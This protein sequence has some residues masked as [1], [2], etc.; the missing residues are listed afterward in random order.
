MFTGCMN[1]FLY[2]FPSLFI[3]HFYCYVYISA[4]VSKS[5]LYSKAIVEIGSISLDLDL[6]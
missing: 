4:I 2:E 6:V 3:L 1:Y 5:S